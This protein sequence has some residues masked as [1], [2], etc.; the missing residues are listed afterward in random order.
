[1]TVLDYCLDVQSGLS[2]KRPT[3]T[4]A[5]SRETNP[6]FMDWFEATGI[7]GDAVTAALMGRQQ[8][9][10]RLAEPVAERWQIS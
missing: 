7:A 10:L 4:L 9:A 2:T 6:L 3:P 5:G 1:M 8:R